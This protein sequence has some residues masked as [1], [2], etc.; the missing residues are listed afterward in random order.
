MHLR[1]IYAAEEAR[2][3]RE[4]EERHV[5]LLEVRPLPPFPANKD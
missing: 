4:L 1:R 5:G 2:R 3:G